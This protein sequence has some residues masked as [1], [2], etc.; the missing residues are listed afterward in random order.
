SSDITH[1]LHELAHDEGMLKLLRDEQTQLLQQGRNMGGDLN[2]FFTVFRDLNRRIHAQSRR[3]SE[4]VAHE[5]HLDGISR[6]EVKIESTI[7]QLDFWEPLKRFSDLHHDWE[8]S[9]EAIPS[10][11]YLN[12]LEIGRASCRER[13]WMS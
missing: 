5:M 4:E 7:D 3:L 2:K 8:R 11:E 6:A 12:A 10:E 1:I 9:G 13:V